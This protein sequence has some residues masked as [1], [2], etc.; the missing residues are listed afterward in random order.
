MS[1]ENVHA[2]DTVI[3][4]TNFGRSRK[5]IVIDR[6][7]KTQLIVEGTRFRRQTGH[8]VGGRMG[9]FNHISIRVPREGEVE[10]VQYEN[11]VNILRREITQF[12]NRQAVQNLPL[13]SL[14]R[15]FT[16]M[17]AEYAALKNNQG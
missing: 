7:T 2:G 6:E 8:I 13:S 3:L 5:V 16:V 10:K 9:G 1:L 12:G 14:E 15:I 17:E 4:T 11:R